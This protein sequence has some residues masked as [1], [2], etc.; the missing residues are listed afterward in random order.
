[1]DFSALFLLF[2]VAVFAGIVAAVFLAI[3]LVR[4]RR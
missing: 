3:A 2:A 4:R 1:M